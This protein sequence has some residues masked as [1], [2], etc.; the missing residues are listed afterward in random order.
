MT[1]PS[2]PKGGK[3]EGNYAKDTGKDA[4]GL[5]R[6]NEAADVLA[7]QGYRT[8][9]LDEVPNGNAFDG[10]GYGIDPSKSPDFIIE[11]QVFDCYAPDKGTSLQNILTTLRSKT[12]KQARRIVLNLN[13][14]PVEKRRE[15]IDY[16]ISQTHKDLKHLDELLIIEGRQVTRGY[17]RFD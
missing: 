16:L 13:D 12:T 11:G 15:L 17:W 3:P 6:Q 1:K 8:I 2:L 10:N 9:M 4:R 5:K 14:Y 7:E